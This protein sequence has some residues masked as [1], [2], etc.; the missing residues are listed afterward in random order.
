[1]LVKDFR[2]T[3]GFQVIYHIPPH[4]P[5]QVQGGPFF[6][7][8]SIDL[9]EVNALLEIPT[10]KSEVRYSSQPPPVSSFFHNFWVPSNP[11]LLPYG[12]LLRGTQSTVS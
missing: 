1:M 12:T 11:C 2:V 8:L 9:Q 4:V 5:A 3:M 7:K 6:P 10:V